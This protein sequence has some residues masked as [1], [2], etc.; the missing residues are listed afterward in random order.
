MDCIVYGVTKSQ[1]RLNAFHF[2]F[3]MFYLTYILYIHDI[4]NF[5]LIFKKILIGFMAYQQV[6]KIVTNV[7]KF[8]NIFIEKNLCK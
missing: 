7:K 4:P 2:H 6:F 5:F 3:S 8:S 1:T